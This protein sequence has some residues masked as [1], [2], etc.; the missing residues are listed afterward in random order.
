MNFDEFLNYCVN[1]TVNNG[2]TIPAVTIPRAELEVVLEDL[3]Q[4]FKAMPRNLA[5]S[6]NRL[7]RAIQVVEGWKEGS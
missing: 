3:R 7:G 5:F 4:T 2:D 1:D 6:R